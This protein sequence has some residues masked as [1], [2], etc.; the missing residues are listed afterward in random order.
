MNENIKNGI[1]KA[2]KDE[3]GSLYR[4]Y[5]DSVKQGMEKPCFFILDKKCAFDKLLGK[6]AAVTFYYEIEVI[7]EERANIEEILFRMFYALEMIETVDGKM[8]GRNMSFA[9]EKGKGIFSIQFKS[10]VMFRENDQEYMEY[11]E[12]KDV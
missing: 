4:I 9:I 11:L 3:F 10:L 5:D 1:A 6:R 12:R 8:F 2:L 7:D